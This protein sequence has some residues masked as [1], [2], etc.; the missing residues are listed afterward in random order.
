[1][2]TIRDEGAGIP[3]EDLPRIR[4]PFFTTKQDSG[5]IGLGLSISS[6]IVEEHRRQP[7]A[8]PRE[9]GAGTTVTITLPCRRRRRRDAVKGHLHERNRLP[10]TARHA[11]RRRGPG[12]DQL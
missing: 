5:G 9:P 2:I 3:P 1:M 4:E 10:A 8:S 7:A 11:G 12:P 6:K